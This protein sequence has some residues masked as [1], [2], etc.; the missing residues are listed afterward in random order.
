MKNPDIED[1][2]F[3]NWTKWLSAIIA[4]SVATNRP[5]A[6]LKQA[7]ADLPSNPI[8]SD[9]LNMSDTHGKYIGLDIHYAV[10][11]IHIAV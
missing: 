10:L 9:D 2:F 3:D 6:G 8:E 5:S 7:L 1:L 4:Y 11:H